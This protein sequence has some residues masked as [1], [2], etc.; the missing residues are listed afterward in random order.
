MTEGGSPL[1]SSTFASIAEA[2][3]GTA[4]GVLGKLVVVEEN[5]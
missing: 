1:L 5:P 4:A 2:P 3:A